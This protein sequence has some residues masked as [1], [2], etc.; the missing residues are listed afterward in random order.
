MNDQYG[1]LLQDQ[2][3]VHLKEKNVISAQRTGVEVDFIP[4]GYTSFQFLEP[5]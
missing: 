1:Y 4:E 5:S 2:F 3:S